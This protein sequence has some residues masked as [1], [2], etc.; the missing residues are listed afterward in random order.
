MN[1]R[2]VAAPD[3]MAVVSPSSTAATARG[4]RAFRQACFSAVTAGID[5]PHRVALYVLVE[6][7][8]DPANRLA[9]A[10]AHA[11]R[12]GVEVAYRVCDSTGMTDPFTRPGLARAYAAIGRGEIHGIVAASRTDISAF[13]RP[14]EQELWR[15]RALPGFLLLAHD[16]THA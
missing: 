3:G 5:E 13:D 8:R 1:T 6:P 10:Q 16:E 7:G 4:F 2:L 15:L 11:N 14:Y 9:V 12:A